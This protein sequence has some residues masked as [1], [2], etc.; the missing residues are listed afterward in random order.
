MVMKY[1]LFGCLLFTISFIHAQVNRDS[2]FVIDLNHVYTDQELDEVPHFPDGDQGFREIYSLIRYPADAREKGIKGKVT[3]TV[4][5]ERDGSLTNAKV[6]KSVYPSLDAEA[7]RV[8]KLITSRMIPGKIN[9]I[10]VRSE[11]SFPI[12]YYLQ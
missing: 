3:I 7:L 1:F 11:Y 2:S 5:I 12:G 10:P 4:V 6:T 9:G 8:S